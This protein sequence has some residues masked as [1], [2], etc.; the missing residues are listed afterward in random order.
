MAVLTLLPYKC[1][2]LINTELLTVNAQP[3]QRAVCVVTY[4]L[5]ALSNAMLVLEESSSQEMVLAPLVMLA[6]RSAKVP[7]RNTV[8]DGLLVRRSLSTQEP[9]DP[10]SSIVLVIKTSEEPVSPTV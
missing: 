10:D 8:K 5:K 1:A 3:A 6:A 7:E 4:P 9:K 2:P